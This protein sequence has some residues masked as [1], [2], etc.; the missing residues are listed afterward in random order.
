MERLLQYSIPHAFQFLTT[1]SDKVI[2]EIIQRFVQYGRRY[3]TKYG[4]SREAYGVVYDF[5]HHIFQKTQKTT[6]EFFEQNIR[7]LTKKGTK[8][9]LKFHTYDLWYRWLEAR[10]GQVIYHMF[11]N[12]IDWLGNELVEPELHRHIRCVDAGWSSDTT[13]PKSTG[14]RRRMKGAKCFQV[15]H[16]H[17][18]WTGPPT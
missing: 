10:I 8:K 7:R 4:L 12:E 1:A 13:N 15:R 6:P 2:R 16:K 3:T 11:P 17:I 14:I 9:Q 18:H 5:I